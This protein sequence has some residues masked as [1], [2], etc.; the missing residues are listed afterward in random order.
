MTKLIHIYVNGVSS[1]STCLIERSSFGYC[2]YAETFDGELSPDGWLP[3]VAPSPLPYSFRTAHTQTIVNTQCS[4]Q[5]QYHSDPYNSKQMLKC[6][7][8]ND[9]LAIAG[10]SINHAA[11][12][13]YSD[14]QDRWQPYDGE[15]H[16]HPFSTASAVSVFELERCVLIVNP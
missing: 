1:C 15:S 4:I 3:H 9:F 8:G 10:D 2:R 14:G 16:T 13:V 7:P 12:R 11:Q 5:P 6:R